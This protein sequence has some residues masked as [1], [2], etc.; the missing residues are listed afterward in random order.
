M[1]EDA[2]IAAVLEDPGAD[3]HRLVYADW[4]EERGDP[5]AEFLR[6]ECELLRLP[7][8]D[9]RFPALWTRLYELS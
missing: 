7:W 6:A 1:T 9:G 5:R 8:G 3:L 2:F 4:L